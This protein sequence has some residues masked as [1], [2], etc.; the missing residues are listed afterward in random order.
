VATL[1]SDVVVAYRKHGGIAGIDQTLTVHAD[2]TLGLEGPRL[3]PREAHV[4]PTDLEPLRTLLSSAEFAQLRTL[5]QAAGAD[6]FV[7]EITVPTTV[8]PRTIV[9]MT[10]AP[11]PPV[12]DQAV[13]ELERLRQRTGAA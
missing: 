7:A 2:G 10:G 13:A 6:L 12:L 5:Y 3:Q 9:T 11:S 8:G 1:A 4:P